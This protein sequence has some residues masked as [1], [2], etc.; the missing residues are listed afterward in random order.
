MF[1][2]GLGVRCIEVRW[3]PMALLASTLLDAR[4][5]KRSMGDAAIGCTKADE[6]RRMSMDR[7]F[8]CELEAFRL[9]NAKVFT[10]YMQFP[11]RQRHSAP[12]SRPLVSTAFL[13]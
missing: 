9:H 3:R 4:M 11:V 8:T 2:N 13:G 12:G 6:L 10:C 7:D 5:H 1:E